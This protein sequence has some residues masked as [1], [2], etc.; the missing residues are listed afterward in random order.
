MKIRFIGGALHG[1]T[2]DVES[3]VK[4][5][6]TA[7]Y[8]YGRTAYDLPTYTYEPIRRE[9]YTRKR[10]QLNSVV[11]VDVMVHSKIRQENEMLR[12]L[13]NIIDGV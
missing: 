8:G 3:S 12:A 2:K 4:H 6:E 11:A 9:T 1:D 5:V 13:A 7:A 10:L